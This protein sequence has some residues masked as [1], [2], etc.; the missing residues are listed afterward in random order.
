MQR[1]QKYMTG[2]EYWSNPDSCQNGKEAYIDE[3]VRK[4]YYEEI[5]ESLS[6][7]FKCEDTFTIHEFGCGW[8]TNLAGIKNVFPNSKMSANDVWKDALDYVQL[9]RSYIDIIEMDTIDF[10]KEK[11][12]LNVVYDVIITNAHLIHI[13]DERLK[14]LKDLHK[15][16]NHAILQENIQG[17]EKI[18]ICMES[19]I[20]SMKNLPDSDYQYNFR[21]L[22]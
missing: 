7:I 16:C 2:I 15:I 22:C 1:P 18:V 8:G 21:K 19:K 11:C 3:N 10:I 6:K 14:N 12:E 17:L 20:L 4:K 9:H 5:I 13:S